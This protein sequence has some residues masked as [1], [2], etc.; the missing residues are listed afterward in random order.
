VSGILVID[1]EPDILLLCRLNLGMDGTDIRGVT[2]GADGLAAAR[3]DVPEVV[4]LDLMMP[5]MDGF[6]VLRRLKDDVRT[7][8]VPVVVLTA[9]TSSIDREQCASLGAD[10]FITKPFVPHELSQVVESLRR[11]ARELA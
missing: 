8:D 5:G 7:G 11:G 6:E 10:S 1:D 4:V 2:S 9:K 3:T